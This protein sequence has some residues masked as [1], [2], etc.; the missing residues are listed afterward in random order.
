VTAI[1][2]LNWRGAEPIHSWT[3][4]GSPAR[5][6]DRDRCTR[7]MQVQRR[8][9]G[10]PNTE[11][12][13]KQHG[14]AGSGPWRALG[15]DAAAA[16]GRGGS[17]GGPPVCAGGAEVGWTAI[18]LS[19]SFPDELARMG[20]VSRISPGRNASQ[21]SLISRP[22]DPAKSRLNS[23]LSVIRRVVCQR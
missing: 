22:L 11:P 13:T 7:P 12:W 23:S 19:L 1:R 5:L 16:A 6:P 17:Q 2:N 3:N 18:C 9:P 20:V 8:S 10:I 21:R 4:Y 15:G 14:P